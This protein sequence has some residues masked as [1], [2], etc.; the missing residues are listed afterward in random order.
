MRVKTLAST[1]GPGRLSSDLIGVGLDRGDK[2]NSNQTADG[3]SGKHPPYTAQRAC[4]EVLGM[5]VGQHHIHIVLPRSAHPTLYDCAAPFIIK[6]LSKSLRRYNFYGYSGG[7]AR[8]LTAR[9]AARIRNALGLIEDAIGYD[10]I[11]DLQILG[12]NTRLQ[13]SLWNSVLL[14]CLEHGLVRCGKADNLRSYSGKG[15]LM[16]R[17]LSRSGDI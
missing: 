3:V 14:L 2:Q 5:M 11:V 8:I 7:L 17:R 16:V 9:T 15:W 1:G 4:H 6:D 12:V 10:H 13:L